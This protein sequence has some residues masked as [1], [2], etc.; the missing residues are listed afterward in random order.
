[1]HSSS[2]PFVLRALPISFSLHWSTKVVLGLSN[3][4]WSYFNMTAERWNSAAGETAATRERLGKHIVSAKVVT[5]RNN[6]SC[7][8]RYCHAGS[9][10]TMEHVILRH[11]HQQT[12]D[13]LCCIRAEAISG[14]KK[15]LHRSPASRRRWRKGNTV[16]GGITGS[17]CS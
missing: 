10:A 8:K 15:H 7:G 1:M 3:C 9:A 6:M 16:P 2:P 5:S 11:P 13:N 12:N 17:P 14:E 4:I